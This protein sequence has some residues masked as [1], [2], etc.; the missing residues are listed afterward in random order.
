MDEGLEHLVWRRALQR[1][2]YWRLPKEHLRGAFGINHN[3]PRKPARTTRP[4]T[5]VGSCFYCNSFKGADLAGIDDKSGRIVRLF[6][7][8]RHRWS[9]HFRWAGPVLVGKTAI[10]RATIAV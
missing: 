9:T 4:S 7:P 3:I 6:H 1:W 5:L 8:R 10:G 2:E